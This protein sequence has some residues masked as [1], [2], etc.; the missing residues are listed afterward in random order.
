MKGARKEL[1]ATG[2]LTR[3]REQFMKVKDVQKRSSDY[4]LTDCLMSG[5]AIFGLKY[6]SLLQFDKTKQEDYTRHNLTTLYGVSKAPC[7]TQ[8]R[9]RLD[10]VDTQELSRAFNTVITAL[11]RG[12]ELEGYAFYEGYYLVPLDATGF[13]SSNDIHCESCCQKHHRDGSITYYHQML[14]AVIVHPAYKEVFPFAPEAIIAQDGH[15]KNDC[16]RNAAKRLLPRLRKE[17]PHLKMIIAGDGLYSNGPFIH[18]LNS[19]SMRYILTAKPDDHAYLMEF[20]NVAEKITLDRVD[21]QN[22]QH[23]YEFCNGLPLNDTHADVLVNVIHYT[24]TL[25]DGTVQHFTW[26]TDFSV[27]QQAA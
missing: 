23:H 2:L 27:P 5:L 22:T 13:F 20:F 14:S 25:S 3:V 1:S 8:L 10:E 16:E 15:R 24:Q 12:K 17:H 7:D 6:P 9:K 26:V 21:N 11:Q 18:L 19:L 4:S